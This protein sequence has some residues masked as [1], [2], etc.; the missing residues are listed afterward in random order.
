MSVYSDW[1]GKSYLKISLSKRT[2]TLNIDNQFKVSVYR[3]GQPTKSRTLAK[4]TELQYQLN[5]CPTTS[6]ITLNHCRKMESENS[7]MVDKNEGVLDLAPARR[8]LSES[9]RH[10]WLD[11]NI[12]L[13]LRRKIRIVESGGK[14][15]SNPGWIWCLCRVPNN[16]SSTEWKSVRDYFCRNRRYRMTLISRKEIDDVCFELGTA[17]GRLSVSRT[18]WKE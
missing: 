14:Q 2:K 11:R 13:Q 8:N 5:V 6:L 7:D 3:F 12:P 4:F 16:P 1:D 9:I 18:N 17:I 10:Y 15:Y